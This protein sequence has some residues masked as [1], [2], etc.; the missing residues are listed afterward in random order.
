M[1]VWN[2]WQT[3]AGR[4]AQQIRLSHL[5]ASSGELAEFAREVVA[6]RAEY[7]DVLYSQV[8]SDD[9]LAGVRTAIGEWNELPR[10]AREQMIADAGS[11]LSRY[12]DA[13]VETGLPA[14]TEVVS[15]EIELENEYRSIYDL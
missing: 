4:T 12:I 2:P 6:G 3:E 9:G 7:R 1:D 14:P 5:A 15:E 13:V 11:A 10:P 8:L